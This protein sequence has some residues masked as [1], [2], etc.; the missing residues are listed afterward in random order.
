MSTPTINDFKPLKQQLDV[1][2]K[3]YNYHKSSKDL[4]EILMSGNIGSSKSLTMAHCIVSHCIRYNGSAVGIGRLAL[5][6]LKETLALKIREHLYNIG[7]GLSYKYSETRGAFD[8]NNGSKIIPFSW[9]DKNFAKFRSYELSAFAMEEGTE[10]RGEYYKAYFEAIQRVGRLTKIPEKWAMIATNPDSPTH[11]IYKHFYI[12]KKK[13]RIVYEFKAHENPFLPEG[14]IE[15]LRDIL[16]E[17]E[18]KRM[19]EGQWVDINSESIYYTYNRENNYVNRKYEVATRFPIF[20]C[21]DFNIGS[22]KPLSVAFVQHIKGQTHVFNEVVIEGQNTREALDEAYERK[23]FNY[24]TV[25][26]IHGDAAG[27]HRDTRSKQT[28]YTIIEEFMKEKRL[29][30]KM[31][32]PRSNPSIRDRHNLVNGRICNARG[33]RN[34][35]VYLDA[36]TADEGFCS[37]KFKKGASY[38]E[39]DS[40]RF[41]HI[42]TAIGYSICQDVKESF[43][44]EDQVT[45]LTRFG[46]PR[47]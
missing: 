13:S 42:T 40:D 27:N 12:K 5:P 1:I 46:L 41:Q 14:Y 37:T 18:A 34:L 16:D 9:T 20:V 29:T 15:N 45:N 4:L 22:G 30:Y 47:R 25:Y 23:L 28:D 35:F 44:A 11:W 8:F 31:D 26:V 6:R 19:L 24:K 17:K 10:N 36:P 38:L 3:V 2:K 32:V 43:I 39:D 7:G 33:E 21:F